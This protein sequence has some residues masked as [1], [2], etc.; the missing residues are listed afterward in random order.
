VHECV[1]LAAQYGRHNEFFAAELTRYIALC[2]PRFQAVEKIRKAVVARGARAGSK[3]ALSGKRAPGKRKGLPPPR[4]DLDEYSLKYPVGYVDLEDPAGNKVLHS[5]S[6]FSGSL[7]FHTL[8]AFRDILDDTGRAAPKAYMPVLQKFLEDD[9]L[10]VV[11]FGDWKAV[12]EPMTAEQL[13]PDASV[14]LV[15]ELPSRYVVYD[16]SGDRVT[17]GYIRHAG[18]AK[19]ARDLFVALREAE[20]DLGRPLRVRKIEAD[21]YAFEVTVD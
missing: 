13:F 16:A 14:S 3:A 18:E 12:V 5:Q 4:V 19:M 2:A 1:H 11:S 15:E 10:R 9:G 17:G 20:R 6:P 8:D 7:S 21:N